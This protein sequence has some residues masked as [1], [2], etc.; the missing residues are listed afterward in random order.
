MEFSERFISKTRL[1]MINFVI[2]RI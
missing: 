1:A 2:E